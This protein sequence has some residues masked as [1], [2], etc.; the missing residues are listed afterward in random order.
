[1]AHRHAAVVINPAKVT[2][3]VSRQA[4]I[5]AALAD[6]GY[7]EPMWL[8]TTPE[9]PGTGQARQAV[10]AGVDTVFACG[11]DGTVTACATALAG[12]A[13]ALAVIPSGTGNLLATNLGL[14]T[15]PA[16]AVALAVHGERRRIDV[17]S[18]GTTRFVVMAGMG[19]D[20]QLVGEA[21]EALKARIG[22][23]AYILSAVRHLRDRPMRVRLSLDGAAPMRVRARTVLIA[24][25]GR[26]PGG[27]NLLPEAV[28]DDGQLD[29]AVLAPRGLADWVRLGWAVLRRRAHPNLL[30]V[31]RAQR[32]HLRSD[33]DQPRQLDGDAIDAGRELL[34]SVEPDNLLIC[35]PVTDAD[36][37]PLAAR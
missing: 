25:V 15:D 20:A 10:E 36:R 30:R 16:E 5:R 1:M 32:V 2:D 6:V 24:N 11:G 31:Y 12:T 8:Q 29:V 22:W 4:E 18:C 28:P 14:P 27:M 26:L 37:A 23:P 3:L 35:L 9:D 7:P 13:V 33:R 17:G 19:F 21:S 34:A